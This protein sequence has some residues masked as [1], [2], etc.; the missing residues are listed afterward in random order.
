MRTRDDVVDSPTRE[1]ERPARRA[2]DAPQHQ[3]LAL[4]QTV[5]NASLSRVLGSARLQRLRK[6]D[7]ERHITLGY[8]IEGLEHYRSLLLPTQQRWNE[9]HYQEFLLNRL[10][11]VVDPNIARIKE[12]RAGIE[13]EDDPVGKYKEAMKLAKETLDALKQI[14]SEGQ[15]GDQKSVAENF[16]KGTEERKARLAKE[17]SGRKAAAAAELLEQQA[18]AK[19]AARQQAITDTGVVPRADGGPAFVRPNGKTRRDDLHTF[20]TLSY[21]PFGSLPRQDINNPN[22]FIYHLSLDQLNGLLSRLGDEFVSEYDYQGWP[23]TRAPLV[24]TAPG[25]VMPV[26]LM[27]MS[28]YIGAEVFVDWVRYNAGHTGPAKNLSTSFAFTADEAKFREFGGQIEN[29]NHRVYRYNTGKRLV[30]TNAR[31]TVITYYEG[32]A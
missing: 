32:A 29:G 25:L 10:G 13:A 21:K 7:E 9:Y 30:T 31:D 8:I 1:E 15:E 28:A 22:L 17:L 4:Q 2:P 23:D 20:V 11:D 19:A 16:D 24:A 27:S 3:L 6:E 18:L 26:R 5:G 12:L 14:N